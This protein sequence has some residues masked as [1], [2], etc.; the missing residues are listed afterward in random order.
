M[1]KPRVFILIAEP[2]PGSDFLVFSSDF[3]SFF[4]CKWQERMKSHAVPHL[5]PNITMCMLL[6]IFKIYAFIVKFHVLG[7]F[8]GKCFRNKQVSEIEFFL[9][10]QI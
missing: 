9:I 8:P 10:F 3:M 6:D 4:Q 2:P 7:D 1:M 5:C